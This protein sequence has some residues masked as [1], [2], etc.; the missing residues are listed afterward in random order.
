MVQNQQDLI[1]SLNYNPIIFKTNE[2]VSIIKMMSKIC[3]LPFRQDNFYN[4]YEVISPR[5]LQQSENREPSYYTKLVMPTYLF[6]FVFFI[7]DIMASILSLSHWINNSELSK[8]Q[9]AP[10][11]YNLFTYLHYDDTNPDKNALGIIVNYNNKMLERF[12]TN[13][14]EIF[15]GVVRGKKFTKCN[16]AGDTC[17]KFYL[18]DINQHISKNIASADLYLAYISSYKQI[19]LKKIPL[20]SVNTISNL[21][22]TIDTL[23]NAE[24]LIQKIHSSENLSCVPLILSF[25]YGN[26]NIV[27]P[28]LL[29][30]SLNAFV[31]YNSDHTKC[32][33]FNNCLSSVT[34]N[35]YNI[36][37]S[38]NMDNI[39]YDII[40]KTI[41]NNFNI[42]ELFFYF[43][44]MDIEPIVVDSSISQLPII[45]YIINQIQSINSSAFSNESTNSIVE[46]YSDLYLINYIINI[47]EFITLSM[48]MPT[49]LD[50]LD[51]SGDI[52]I[53]SLSKIFY[54][55]G[56]WG[57]LLQGLLSGLLLLSSQTLSIG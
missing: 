47:L 34:T 42:M 53:I 44:P 43:S 51:F 4:N 57:S 11:I 13:T 41:N 31:R 10:I 9:A 5:L 12:D 19:V 1:D 2:V 46:K 22:N 56:I 29:V 37:L 14:A 8:S 36:K 20:T 33:Y 30:D 6:Q 17:I 55:I 32:F 25:S 49:L 50:A 21:E 24:S 16:I 38:Y 45:E 48:E 18:N 3:S 40:S 26:I 7:N 28:S 39:S 54:I 15:N 52:I 23:I 27:C 35:S